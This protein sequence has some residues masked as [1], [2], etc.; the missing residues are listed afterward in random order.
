MRAEDRRWRSHIGPAESVPGGASCALRPA[1]RR[2]SRH[3]FASPI[4]PVARKL[5]DDGRWLGDARL[6]SVFAPERRTRLHIET[7]FIIG[8]LRDAAF[9]SGGHHGEDSSVARAAGTNCS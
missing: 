4:I 2:W 8:F 9:I 5:V 6:M 3:A 1:F 7:R